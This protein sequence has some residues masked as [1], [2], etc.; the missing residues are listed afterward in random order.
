[1]PAPLTASARCPLSP[2]EKI[3]GIVMSVK[4]VG[5]NNPDCDCSGMDVSVF[6]P[7]DPGDGCLSNGLIQAGSVSC[8][9]GGSA[10]GLLSWQVSC[11]EDT[12]YVMGLF[13][14][15]QGQ[16]EGIL[17]TRTFARGLSCSAM[18]VS[19]NDSASSPSKSDFCTY[20]SAVLTMVPVVMA[21]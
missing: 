8:D 21:G 14:F 15:S 9:P 2:G 1:M 18:T 16:G 11:D 13:Q 12:V 6:V 4:G 5:N 7:A 19:G 20:E 10:E 17:V 3:A